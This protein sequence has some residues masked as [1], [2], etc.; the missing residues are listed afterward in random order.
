MHE[1][2]QA[3][4]KG[5]AETIMNWKGGRQSTNSEMVKGCQSNATMS[6]L[7]WIMVGK[8]VFDHSAEPPCDSWAC[9]LGWVA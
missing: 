7:V 5:A 2:G 9:R 1:N 3:E 8:R 4:N 6:K